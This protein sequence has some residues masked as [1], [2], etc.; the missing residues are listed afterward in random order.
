MLVDMMNKCGL[1][2]IWRK[3]NRNERVFSR[4]IVVENK[5]IQ[6]RIDYILVSFVISDLVKN[7]HYTNTSLSDHSMVV[8]HLDTK[9]SERGPGLWIHN[10][11]LLFDE[12]Y[13]EKIIGR[14]YFRKRTEM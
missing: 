1:F 8:L 5:L 3:R 9:K 14:P 13:K 10:N 2:D 7:I 6:S 4:K 11:S 12:I